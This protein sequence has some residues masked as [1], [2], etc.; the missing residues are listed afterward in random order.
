MMTLKP[1]KDA[2]TQEL[3]N[4]SRELCDVLERGGEDVRNYTM[5]L[6]RVINREIFRREHENRNN[7]VRG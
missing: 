2:S 6:F 5:T 1:F 4:E 3:R 7:A